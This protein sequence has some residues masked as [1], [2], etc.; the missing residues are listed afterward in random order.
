MHTQRE[1]RGSESLRERERDREK[2][3]ESTYCVEDSCRLDLSQVLDI[4]SFVL[5][6]SFLLLYPVRS[7]QIDPGFAVDADHP[8]RD[9]RRDRR[10][11]RRP[12]RLAA[13]GAEQ[14]PGLRNYQLYHQ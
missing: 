2:E 7:F 6:P 5:I 9:Q 14:N 13:M 4:R 3:R 12:Q 11:Q 10:R 8:L 1:E